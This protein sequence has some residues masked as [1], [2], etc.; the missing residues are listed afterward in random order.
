MFL[1]GELSKAMIKKLAEKQLK[2]NCIKPLQMTGSPIIIVAAVG[3]AEAIANACKDN[4]IKIS[5][6]CD[7]IQAKSK[8]PFCGIEVV[9]TP[10]LPERFPEARF[11]IASQHIQDCLEQ[12]TSLGYN[13]FYSPLELLDNYNLENNT[14]NISNAYLQA[15]I[16]VCRKSHEAY[17]GNDQKIYM[18]SIDLMITT[19]CSLK[20]ESCSNLMQY[21]ESPQN[22]EYQSILDSLEIISANVDEIAEFRLIGGEPLMNRGWD[23]IVAGISK[24]YPDREIFI[25]TNG[26]IAPKDDKLEPLMGKKVN[27]IISEYGSLSRNLAKLHEQLDKFNI[28]Y[29][30]TKADHWVDCSNIK[31]HKRTASQLKEVFKQ[32]CVK[33][34]Y[35]L[36]DG[37]LYRCPF[38]ANAAVLKAIPDNPAN[39]VD[40]LSKTKNIKQQIKRLVKVAKFFP[41]CDFCDGRPYDGTSKVGYDGKGMIEAG[42][43][44]TKPLPYKKYD[45]ITGF[46]DGKNISVNKS[47]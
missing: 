26:T 31:H 34:I 6:I 29:V 21:F 13:E 45:F 35:T 5:A 43:Q 40:L 10:T 24:K 25:Y 38:I 17:L 42:I 3:E 27:F 47:I 32:C 39:Y 8:L 46:D 36:L 4:N 19:R 2:Y 1:K 14:H 41:A 15:R 44:T 33:Y 22:Y 18:R 30:S 20:C 7:N 16:S 9:H 37:K 11:I 23:K 12:L 28:N